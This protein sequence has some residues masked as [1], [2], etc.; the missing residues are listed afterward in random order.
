MNVHELKMYMSFVNN[1][2]NFREIIN[3]IITNFQYTVPGHKCVIKMAADNIYGHK[4]YFY[5]FPITNK[6]YSERLAYH[7]CTE[8]GLW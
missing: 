1:F 6:M 8:Q 2:Q 3:G 5:F 7:S 4:S